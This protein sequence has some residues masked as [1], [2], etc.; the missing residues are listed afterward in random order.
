MRLLADKILNIRG[1]N[2]AESLFFIYGTFQKLRARKN[3]YTGTVYI[4][5]N[6]HWFAV[7]KP[8][9]YLFKANE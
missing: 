8:S 1:G 7:P 6:H 5:I 4:Y 2:M 3:K 9:Q